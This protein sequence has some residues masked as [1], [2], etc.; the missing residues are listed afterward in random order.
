[1]INRPFMHL[2]WTL[3][4]ILIASCTAS[5]GEPPVTVRITVIDAQAQVV[6]GAN[7]EV[8]HD[9][10]VVG[11]G[12]TDE[13]GVAAVTL[14]GA[15]E[16]ELIVSR[17]GFVTTK[18]VLQIAEGTLSQQVDVVLP[19]S[20]LSKQEVN[21]T[22]AS[23]NPTTESASLPATI[24]AAQAKISPDK[25]ATL[26]DALPL[27]PGVVRATDGTV[28]IAGYGEA[29]SALL[30]N[31]VNVTDP[32]TG[33]FGLSIPIDSVETISVSEMPYLAEYGKFSAGV[34]A[35]ET[36]RGGE[37]WDWSLN[38]PLPDFRIRSA[39]LQGIRDASPRLNFSGPLVP[40]KLYFLEGAEYL[41]Y[42]R[43]VYT[44]P[45]GSNETKSQA[46]NSFTQMD[47][48]VSANHTVTA[49]YHI[50][51]QT[52]DYAG[53]N[54]F[55]PQPV[56]P[57]ANFREST[58]TVID[59]MSI[60]GGI[61]Q[62]TFANTRVSSGIEPLGPLD[63][64]LSPG[65][66]SGNYFN[67]QNR[68]ATRYQWLES[69][70][71]RTVHF[72]GEHALTFGSLVSHSENEGQF[73]PRPVLVKDVLGHLLQKIDFSGNG[74]FDLSDAEPAI[75]AQDHWML[76]AHLAL[77][78]GM[79]L[80]AQTITHTVRSAPRV[81]F[82]W[83]PSKTSNTVFRGGVGVFYDSVPLDVYAFNYYPQQTVTTYNTAGAII[84]GPR[85]YLNIIDKTS[86]QEGFRFV[87]R[88]NTAGNFA[89]Y[90]LAGNVEVEHSFNH[91]LMLRL[92]Y[93]QSVAQDRITITPETVGS[94]GLFVLGSAGTAHTRQ[95][96]VT[97][98]LGA[99]PTRQFYFSYVRQHARG[100]ISDANSYL[101]NFPFPVVRQG[102][103]ASL[104][105]EIPNRFL[106]WGTYS[107][108]RKFMV[109]PKVEMR[110]GFPYQK[111]DVFQNY[112]ANSGSQPRFPRYFSFDLRVSKDI[113]VASKHAIRL[114]GSVQNM[115]NHFNALEVHANTADP[116]LGTFIGNY[117]RRFTVDF[118][119]LY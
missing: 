61:L 23:T 103:V 49:S 69:W 4:A 31:S 1:M 35:A 105:S 2:A 94:Q 44:L 104:P 25:P 55:S 113:M 80:E 50:A 46:I 75:Y 72:F 79:R 106:L 70:K 24:S 110:N 27:V 109:V 96:E 65:G 108:P 82:A 37:K 6:A 93:L 87:G 99:K 26:I 20:A 53:L 21:V 89:P 41:L 101:G 10:S 47:W 90:S 115:T 97:S 42:K 18:A 52:L 14:I 102:I 45:Y 54:F 34:V 88:S 56:T 17:N 3:I 116:L 78:M 118:D 15:G 58:A 11:N 73:L 7:I 60:G 114:S 57:N 38:D 67:Q 68:R 13:H 74:A 111:T 86:T 119:F 62:S 40:G 91:V 8:R 76:S 59:R 5:Y 32:A 95:F 92:K 43:E 9:G 29:H 28:Q 48:I 85:T 33:G 36:R 117:G 63:M 112:V 100:D 98:R 107:L 77:D 81:G 51:P 83:N 22:A 12:S 30:V 39:H 71:P 84:D 19:Q 16:F 64:I 66:N